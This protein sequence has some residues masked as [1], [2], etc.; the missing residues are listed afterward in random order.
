MSASV[1]E[2]AVQKPRLEA[3]GG[4]IDKDALEEDHM[5]ME[6]RIDGPA[7]ALHKCDR[8]GLDGGPRAPCCTA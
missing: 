4:A 1:G 7:K 2:S 3:L 5:E 8:A 6:I